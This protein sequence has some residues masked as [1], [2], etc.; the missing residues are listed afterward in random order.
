MLK[1]GLSMVR[2]FGITTTMEYFVNGLFS[3]VSNAQGINTMKNLCNAI[4]N[5]NKESFENIMSNSGS[6][7]ASLSFPVGHPFAD[8]DSAWQAV[9]GIAIELNGD[10]N[11]SGAFASVPV[12]LLLPV[13]AEEEKAGE[14]TQFASSIIRM[15]FEMTKTKTNAKT[16]TKSYILKAVE[17]FFDF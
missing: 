3:G 6:Q 5:G 8:V 13:P 11:S 17:F 12:N 2:S 15:E 7:V 10:I 9:Q 16:T 1:V 4:S 14:K